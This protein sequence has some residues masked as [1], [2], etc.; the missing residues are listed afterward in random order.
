MPPLRVRRSAW[1]YPQVEQLLSDRILHSSTHRW[2]H[3]GIT[4]APGG[5][6]PS[7]V[8]CRVLCSV[9]LPNHSCA[10]PAG[11]EHTFDLDSSQPTRAHL[12]AATQFNAMVSL[13]KSGSPKYQ[14]TRSNWKSHNHTRN[15]N[16]QPIASSQTR[17]Q[18]VKLPFRPSRKSF[19]GADDR[20]RR[21]KSRSRGSPKKLSNAT[22]TVVYPWKA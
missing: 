21:S 10:C 12:R 11:R 19:R 2:C 16:M 13:A 7:S 8:S 9:K 6:T 3:F 5:T 14:S 22:M 17:C 20:A 1:T 18:G 4:V 15:N